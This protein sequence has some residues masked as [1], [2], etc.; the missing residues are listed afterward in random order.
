M[1]PLLTPDQAA[2][3]FGVSEKTLR[4]LRDQQ[5]LRYVRLSARTIRY[6]ADD[7]DDFLEQQARRKEQAPCPN[8]SPK[9]ARPT[10]TM[11]SSSKVIA[12]TARPG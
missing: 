12:F 1:T 7:L 5:G 9:R 6:R 10:G 3:H 8:P 2:A 11:I 4:K